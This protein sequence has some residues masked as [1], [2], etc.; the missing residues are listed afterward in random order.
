MHLLESGWSAITSALHYQSAS[1]VLYGEL[2]RFILDLGYRCGQVTWKIATQ[3]DNTSIR[4]TV[5]H[6]VST[7]KKSI[8]GG[9]VSLS[10]PHN[11]LALHFKLLVRNVHWQV[12]GTSIHVFSV[13]SPHNIVSCNHHLSSVST[14]LWGIYWLVLTDIVRQQ[15]KCPTMTASKY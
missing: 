3:R 2:L 8:K 13:S 11:V 15:R 10:S 5:L 7:S 14:Q 4:S 6:W 12:L 1:L 9:P